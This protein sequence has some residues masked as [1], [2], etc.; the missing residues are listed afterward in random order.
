MKWIDSHVHLGYDHD[1]SSANLEEIRELFQNKY[2]DEAVIFCFD[3]EKGIK[4]G[5]KKIGEVLKKDERTLGMC[6]LDPEKHDPSDL[7][8]FNSFSGFKLHPH[9]QN[10]HLTEIKDYLKALE[11]IKKPVLIHIGS[12]GERPHP[13]E[14]VDMAEELNDIKII[15]AH[16]MRGYFFKADKEFKKKIKKNNNIFVDLSFQAS[17]TAIEILVN[18]IGSE[19]LLFASDYPYGH[20]VPVKKSIELAEISKEKKEK[21][22]YKN[23]EK[24]FKN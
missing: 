10:F 9:S 7:K 18:E 1:G 22:A 13:E 6:R 20:P 12:W 4:I 5:N 3:E 8:S 19:R 16:S 17:P 23:A 14:V 21:I 11:D 15:L 24:I 2:I